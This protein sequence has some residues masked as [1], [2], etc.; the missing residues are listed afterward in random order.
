M[1]I[2]LAFR[3]TLADNACMSKSEKK[4]AVNFRLPK[5]ELERIRRAAKL[6]RRTLT[7]FFLLAGLQRCAE[8]ERQE[9]VS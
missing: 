9:R 4:I 3:Y 5:H 2:S 1:Q 6:E 8:I 7:A